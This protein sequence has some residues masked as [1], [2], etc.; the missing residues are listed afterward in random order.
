MAP[1]NGRSW[2]CL[3]GMRKLRPTPSHRALLV[4]AEAENPVLNKLLSLLGANAD[5]DPTVPDGWRVLRFE[6]MSLT[7]AGGATVDLAT[8]Q[9]S[10]HFLTHKSTASVTLSTTTSSSVGGVVNVEK[11]EATITADTNVP[12]SSVAIAITVKNIDLTKV[13]FK[14]PFRIGKTITLS[15]STDDKKLKVN[16]KDLSTLV[17]DSGPMHIPLDN[18]SALN[19]ALV[20]EDGAGGARKIGFEIVI[21]KS[22]YDHKP[23]VSGIPESKVTF[24]WE[25]FRIRLHDDHIGIAA[26]PGDN[27]DL[28]TATFVLPLVQAAIGDSATNA[29]AKL[30]PS[31]AEN[32]TPLKYTVKIKRPKGTL[33]IAPLLWSVKRT[34]AGLAEAGQLA[35]EIGKKVLAVFQEDT[36]VKDTDLSSFFAP[37]QEL[38]G[39]AG[40]ALYFSL[41][42]VK[43]ALN[44]GT[45]LV[46]VIKELDAFNTEDYPLPV[47]LK[48]SKEKD[49][50]KP[51]LVFLVVLH[52]NLWKGRL[53][54]N[55]AYFYVAAGAGATDRPQML[56][57]TAFAMTLP[58]RTV[59]DL[60]SILKDPKKRLPSE[61]HHDGYLDFES[62]DVVLDA[63][64]VSQANRPQLAVLF[65]GGLNRDDDGTVKSDDEKKRVRILLEDFEPEVWPEQPKDESKT[66]QLRLGARGLTFSAKADTVKEANITVA[67]SASVPMR[68]VETRDGLRSGLVVIDNQVR[69]ANLAGRIK[70][71]GLDN[72]EADVALGLRRDKPNEPPVV[73]AVIDIDR[74]DR[75]PLARMQIPLL[76]AQLDDLRMQLTWT[77]KQGSDSSD[78][79][80]RAWAT[81]AISITGDLGS[82]GGIEG[83]D[84]P[85]AIPFRDLDLTRLHN[86]AGQ[87]P[88]GRPVRDE[89]ANVNNGNGG[90][91]NSTPSTVDQV[92]RFELLEKQFRVEFYNS[93]LH[94]DLD[95]KTASF[96]IERARFEYQASSGD[97]DVAIEAGKV[98]LMFDLNKRS[99]KFKTPSSFGL[100]VRIGTQLS[101]AG[102]V[103]WEDTPTEHY[104]RADG[105]LQM[106]GFPEV[107]GSLKLGTGLKEDGKTAPN[108]AIFAELPYE[109]DLFSGVVLKRVGLGLGLNNRL[110][111]I[112]DRPDPRAILANLDHIDP[113]Q[114]RN[115]SFVSEAGVYVSV[116][117]TAM[118]ASNRG[119]DN[120]V[121]A[122]VAKLL[123]SIDTNIDIVAAAQVWLF[124]SP[125]YITQQDHER[126]PALIGAAG[127]SARERTFSLVAQTTP[128]PAIESNQM[129][130]DLL[131]RVRA[132]FSFYLSSELADFYL[133]ESVV[134]RSVVR[135]QH[136]RDGKLSH[137]DRS[138]RS[139]D[140][141]HAG[142]SR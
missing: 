83:L 28:G 24:E 20:L 57:L 93:V 31:S 2:P 14:T 50:S 84:Q 135:Y 134:P 125:G 90:P 55:R 56:D 114:S 12:S 21:P 77:K 66:L 23:L 78:W 120:V 113:K 106:T 53:S 27:E 103:G 19:T 65:P 102:N 85:Q 112:G 127:L 47:A 36:N 73:T 46:D 32:L 105:R 117:A 60:T 42:Q 44:H 9:A 88:L 59:A 96:A 110:A 29:L 95:A 26:D 52:I 115:W 111:G 11:V 137:R 67:G 122:Y 80:F 116:V 40:E 126:R 89:P 37:L 33:D 86:G 13:G 35:E 75:K 45:D 136:C 10:H 91:S 124:S 22:S 108:L 100:Q 118:I 54:S 43:S 130:S 58:I 15:Y 76:K 39:Q 62:L 64:P 7:P 5:A 121:C 140:A 79:D 87:I 1:T 81:G 25:Q 61:E 98:E 132:R 107:A 94:W 68:L 141:S 51:D 101:F 69:Y 119:K 70:I 34:V 92:A 18:D 133:E 49:A 131:S 109:A 129:L 128:R 41:S 17:P 3:A 30:V 16:G 142:T 4:R 8:L 6:D 139:P 99:L 71:P 104:F 138:I 48:V 97:L 123:L 74:T 38:A 82:T 63:Q 72:F